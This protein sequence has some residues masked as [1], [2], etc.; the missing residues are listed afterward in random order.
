MTN[1]RK[2]VSGAGAS[3]VGTK[4]ND[5]TAESSSDGHDKKRRKRSTSPNTDPVST[6][7]SVLVLCAFIS[8]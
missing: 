7:M 8:C 1:K 4:S 5:N 3:N 2:R 6:M